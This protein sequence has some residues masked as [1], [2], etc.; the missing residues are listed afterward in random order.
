MNRDMIVARVSYRAMAKRQNKSLMRNL[1][2]FFGH[3]TRGVKSD[4]AKGKGR[5]VEVNRETE[6]RREGNM[7]LR[8]TTIDEIEYTDGNGPNARENEETKR[9]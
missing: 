3:I 9:D 6:E 8:R 1:G 4:P 5:K 2:E 7:I